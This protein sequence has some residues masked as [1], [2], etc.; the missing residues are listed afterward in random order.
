MGT[1]IKRY[2]KWRTKEKKRE[3]FREMR[4]RVTVVNRS[5][6]R[7]CPKMTSKFLLLQTRAESYW[8][9]DKQSMKSCLGRK[10]NRYY[11]MLPHI[12]HTTVVLKYEFQAFIVFSYLLTLCASYH[13]NIT[14]PLNVDRPLSSHS[15]A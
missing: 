13:I 14:L 1:S 8:N 10:S 12:C 3:Q 9:W 4:G 15:A 11:H 7:L 2:S 5:F 6:N